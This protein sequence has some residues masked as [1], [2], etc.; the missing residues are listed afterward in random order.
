MKR[1]LFVFA[2]LTMAFSSKTFAQDYD[3]AEFKPFK[4]DVSAGYAMPIGGTGSKGGFLF[5]VEPKYAVLPQ[6]SIGIRCEAAITVTGIDYNGNYNNTASAKASS[7]YLLTADYYF[8]SNDFRPFIGV[9]GG[10]Y[11]TA[12]VDLSSNNS[13]MAQGSKPGGIIRTGFEY[14]HARFGVEYNLVG[15]TTVAPSSSTSNDG[16]DVKNAYIGIK[17]GVCIGGGRY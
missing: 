12:G 2:I 16:Y 17:F 7:S 10:L 5:V 11:Q 1:V 4:V 8:S 3:D 13:N 14:R 6:L 15:A 9:G